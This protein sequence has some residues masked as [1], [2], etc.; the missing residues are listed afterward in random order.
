MMR[1]LVTAE[2]WGEY[3]PSNNTFADVPSTNAYYG[4]IERAR[5]HGIIDGYPCGGPGEPCD[6]QNRPYFRPN[7]SLTRGQASK[8]VVLAEG[9][10]LNTSQSS[11]F[12][13][14][15]VGNTW[16]PYV[17][18]MQDYGLVVGYTDNSYCTSRGSP[19][20]PCYVPQDTITRGQMAKVVYLANRGNFGH[21]TPYEGSNNLYYSPGAS[22]SLIPEG[23]LQGINP[24]TDRYKAYAHS[25]QWSYAATDWLQHT[26]VVPT[27]IVFHIFK[28][29]TQT[30]SNNAVGPSPII[31]NAYLSENPNAFLDYE[32][33]CFG[34]P[35]R[36]EVRV[37]VNANGITPYESD[38]Y[39]WAT[40]WQQSNQ[41]DK[42]QT[43]ISNYYEPPSLSPGIPASTRKDDMDV[44]CYF[45]NVIGW[46]ND[47]SV[48]HQ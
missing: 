16:F 26:A 28:A 5:N 3:R 39:V 12:T 23:F 35:I 25:I 20:Q 32:P 10:L 47:N 18:D 21:S 2:E 37:D 34:G 17:Q 19:G 38:Y 15:L 29:N 11:Y 8:V 46:R 43:V 30:C 42:M 1:A 45:N 14:V 31:E 6:S 7:A 33:A 40:V 48:C 27:K 9:W 41:S 13:D 24:S 22:Y 36:Q 44:F 4:F